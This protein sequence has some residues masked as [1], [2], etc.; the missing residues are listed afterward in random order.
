MLTVIAAVSTIA[1]MGIFAWRNHR[2][3]WVKPR[4]PMIECIWTSH[5]DLPA[6]P[7]VSRTPSV[8]SAGM[9]INPTE[10]S[11]QLGSMQ[12]SLQR[13]NAFAVTPTSMSAAAKTAD[14]DRVTT[15]S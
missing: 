12:A 14:R 8:S 15:D 5:Y 9:P 1:L 11:Q 13:A 7:E 6:V 4:K 3:G 2:E 10:F